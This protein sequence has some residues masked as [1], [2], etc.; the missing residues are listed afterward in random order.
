M[1]ILRQL[2]A[3]ESWSG[4]RFI[5]QLR[6]KANFVRTSQARA[7][8]MRTAPRKSTRHVSWHVRV[9]HNYLFMQFRASARAHSSSKSNEVPRNVYSMPLA[10]VSRSRNEQDTNVTTSPAFVHTY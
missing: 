8:Y 6:A 10:I 3:K 2:A 1:L 9:T 7:V 4:L 5:C